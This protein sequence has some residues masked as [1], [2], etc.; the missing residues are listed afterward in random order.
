MHCLLVGFLPSLHGRQTR[1][2][3]MNLSQMDRLLVPVL[4][5]HQALGTILYRDFPTM[6]LGGGRHHYSQC[7]GLEPPSGWH[8]AGFLTIMLYGPLRTW[9]HIWIPVFHVASCPFSLWKQRTRAMSKLWQQEVRSLGFYFNLAIIKLSDLGRPHNLC[10][11]DF[12]PP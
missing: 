3:D 8:Q 6:A 12:S 9:R 4:V 7:T 11:P 2:L 5:A 10:E 1:W